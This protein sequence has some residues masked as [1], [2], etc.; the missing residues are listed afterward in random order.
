MN[1]ANGPARQMPMWQQNTP[2][3]PTIAVLQPVTMTTTAQALAGTG[4]VPVA[5]ATYFGKGVPTFS[6]PTGTLYSNNN[7]TAAGTTL[8]YINNSGAGATGTTWV[9]VTLP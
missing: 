8:L 3:Q 5:V 1:N 4:T 6:A 7:G 9:A 2:Q